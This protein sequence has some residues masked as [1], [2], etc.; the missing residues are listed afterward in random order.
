MQKTLYCYKLNDNTGEIQRIEISDYVELTNS[1]R[2][3]R[4]GGYVEYIYKKDLD[5]VKNNKIYSFDDN[6]DSCVVMIYRSISEKKEKAD[7]DLRKYQAVM[8]QL[9]LRYMSEVSG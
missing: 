5:K 9:S 8:H 2:W 6:M 1:Y 3:E 4:P 7:K